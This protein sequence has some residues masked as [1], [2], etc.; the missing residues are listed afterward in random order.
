MSLDLDSLRHFELAATTLNFR[1]AAGR[2][3]LSPAAF[4]ERIRGL[5]EALGVRL[6]ERTTRSVRLTPA[7]ERLLPYAR[8]SVAAADALQRAANDVREEWEITLGTRYELGL[9]WLTPAL[10]L[11]AEND[12]T[13][14]VHLHVGDAPALVEAV[15]HGRIDAMVSSVRLD[16]EELVSVLLHPEAY[17]FVAA[18]AAVHDAPFHGAEDAARHTLLDLTPGLP[19]FRYLLDRVGGPV[20]PFARRAYLG[21]IGAVRARALGGR[22]VAV[23]PAYFVQA[24]LDAGT[25]V[26]LLPAVRPEADAFRLT[27]RSGHPRAEALLRLAEELRAIPLR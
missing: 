24:D 22:G 16:A 21:G 8:A 6:F 10:D 26:E 18:P 9:S 17:R 13:R 5:E 2:A 11:L 15:R 12:A 14:T 1:A 4:S 20:W 23:L 7:G 3:H 25:L 27:W 19:L